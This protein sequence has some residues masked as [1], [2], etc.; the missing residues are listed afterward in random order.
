ML[1]VTSAVGGRA[2]RGVAGVAV[3]LINSLYLAATAT[4]SIFYYTNVVLHIVLGAV[5]AIAGLR[6]ALRHRAGLPIAVT[7]AALPLTLG[8]LTG[9]A[10]VVTGAT[11]PYQW[12]LLTHIVSAT[13]GAIVLV[14]WAASEGRRRTSGRTRF[15]GAVITLILVL[16]AAIAAS[17]MARRDNARRAAFRI[18]NPEVVP[19]RME[20]EGAGPSSPFFP[21]SANTNVDGIIP[22]NFFLTSAACGR[23]HRD[24]YDQWNSSAHHFSS[25]NNQWYRKSIEYMQ[26]VI[27]T[28]PS[29]WCAGC[30]DHAVFF[31]GRFDRPIREQ[32]DTPEAQAG[33]ACTSCHAITR[34]NGTMGQ[35]DFIVEY[36]ALH[37]L[38]TSENAL[39]R[40]AHDKL[41]YL[42][43]QPHRETFLKPFHREQTPEFCASC[44]KVH[45]DI[46]VNGYRWFRGFNDYDNWQASGV[47]GEGARSFYYPEKPQKCADCHMPLVKSDDPAAKNGMVRSHRFAAANT[48][49]PFVNRDPV[50]LKAVQDFLRDGQISVDVFGIVRTPEDARGIGPTSKVRPN[51][52]SHADPYKE[53]QVRPSNEPRIASTFAVGEESAAFGATEA[54]IRTP[55]QVIAPLGKVDAWVRRGESIRVE[56]VVRTRKVGHFFPGG[57]V[58]A[59]DVWVELEAVDD[60]GRTI[61]HSGSF[62]DG[63]SGE[64]DRGAHIY[65]SLLL[66]ERGNPINK[67]NAWAARS[68]AY[69]RLIPPG[70]ADTVHYRLDIPENA[71]DRITL[72]AKVNYRK[73]AWW[74]TQ[75]AFAGIREPGQP[76]YSVTAAHDDGR[77]VFTGDTSDVSGEVKAIPDIPTTVMAESTATLRVVDDDA[78][79]TEA[80][81]FLDLSV[82]ERW[83][84]YGI[85]LLLQGDLKGAEAAFE[86]VTRME[87][88]YADGWV[89]VGRARLQEGNLAGAEE[90]L[91]RALEIKPTLAK[92]HFFLGNML[93]ND[94]RYD[95]A[96]GHLRTAAS[97]YP[98][99]RVVLNQLG[100]VLFLQRRFADAVVELKKVLAIDPEDLQA[101]YNLMLCYQGL[102]QQDLADRERALYARFKADES[103]QAITGPYRQ[104]HPHDNNERQAIHE[105]RSASPR[106][107]DPR[108]QRRLLTQ[109]DKP[110]DPR[111]RA[112]IAGASP[113]GIR[114]E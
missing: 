98:R 93:K 11:R 110:A 47:S 100:R 80:V 88:G 41:L 4:A 84:D 26:D 30:H 63:R 34:V 104:L 40:Y 43:P 67:R 39:L 28:R 75:W 24:I 17:A 87:P 79:V 3:L 12:L 96:M 45:L 66:D 51:K 77:W 29:K 31:N 59:F 32:I 46:P 38:A 50:Q 13:A 68:V 15:A 37:D 49:L 71:A 52:E 92:T 25:F 60:R 111:P 78:V 48:A 42:D 82:R 44:H 7:L 36:P 64:V 86:K 33:L 14:G 10:L 69:V 109:Q 97:Q 101:H 54:F 70:A 102:G 95:E 6:Y 9:G 2:G 56:V 103:S 89:N 91:R 113:S 114:P 53:G 8:A 108:L 76:A 62:E 72:K 65:R 57:T 20:E 22:A 99:D 18:V 61:F 21:S 106:G 83:N 35:G 23:C 58:D 74:N 105:H 19:A 5:L 90:V 1:R 73:F 16:A 94:G 81:P 107:S 27:G 55:D 112:R 85:G